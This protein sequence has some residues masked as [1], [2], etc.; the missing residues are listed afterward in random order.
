MSTLAVI[1]GDLTENSLLA[2]SIYSL[3]VLR[4]YQYFKLMMMMLPRHLMAVLGLLCLC[5]CREPSAAGGAQREASHMKWEHAVR[6]TARLARH[7]DSMVDDTAHI[8]NMQEYYRSVLDEAR[9]SRNRDYLSTLERIVEQGYNLDAA[10][11][12][13]IQNAEPVSKPVPGRYMVMLQSDTDDRTLDRVMAVM[14][15]ATQTSGGKVRATHMTP[16]RHVGKGL[17]ATLNS[18]AVEL[19]SVC[20]SVHVCL[21]TVAHT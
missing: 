1:A 20:V 11:I 12:Q 3:L 13:S 7:S 15:E 19:V 8:V 6:T 4:S 14:E 5:Q 18:Q 10:T 9:E 17:T 2:H 21:S 16:L